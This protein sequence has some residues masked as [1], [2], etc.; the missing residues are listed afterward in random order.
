MHPAALPQIG[1]ACCPHCQGMDRRALLGLRVLTGHLAGITGG[2]R[3]EAGRHH[4]RR[5]LCAECAQAYAALAETTGIPITFNRNGCYGAIWSP[6]AKTLGPLIEGKD[7]GLAVHQR[8]M[9]MVE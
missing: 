5:R 2:R 7:L 3:G 4:H 9:E 1:A 8:L 6:L